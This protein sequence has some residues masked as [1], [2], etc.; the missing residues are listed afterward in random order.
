MPPSRP[1]LFCYD[2]SE[3]SLRALASVGHLLAAN[4]AVV[5]TVWQP[6]SSRLAESGGFGVFALEQE[7]DLDLQ[8]Q[9]AARD[10][11]Q[12]GA[13]RARERGA[14]AIARVE[15]ADDGVWRTIIEVADEIDAG[16]IVCATRGRGSV[17]SALLGSTSRAVLQHAGR[18]VLISPE[19]R[20]AAVD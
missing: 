7:G 2:G 8:E 19:P 4:D 20:A 9:A 16:L 15:E 6:L 14:D 17:K 5:L 3:P 13:R 12:D 11:A 10:A 1:T 18:P